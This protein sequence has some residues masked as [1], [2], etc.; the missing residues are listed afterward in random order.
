MPEG[1]VSQGL[2]AEGI[3][4][5][6]T[7]FVTL[8]LFGFVIMGSAMMRHEILLLACIPA[9]FVAAIMGFVM[10]LYAGDTFGW[11]PTIAAILLGAVP[12]WVVA[13]RLVARDLLLV[14]YLAWAVALVLALVGFGFP[15]RGV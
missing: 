8:A 5:P 3:A 4:E 7:Y 9:V 11:A 14:V 12:G 2:W 10:A 1:L 15:D 6:A 13:R